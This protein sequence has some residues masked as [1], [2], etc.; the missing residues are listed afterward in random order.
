[1]GHSER[2]DREETGAPSPAVPA[3]VRKARLTLSLVVMLGANLLPLIGVALW[4]WKLFDLIVIY[5]L[6]TLVIGGFGIA[7]MALTTG[8]FAL[9]VV[10]FFIVHFGGFMTGHFVFLNAMF[11]DRSGSLLAGIPDKLRDMIVTDGLWVA[12]IGLAISHGLGFLFRF[13]IPWVRELWRPRGQ[14]APARDTG[15]MGAVMFGPYKRVMIMHVAII[16]GATL[17]AVFGSN[18]AFLALLVALKTASDLYALRREWKSEA[19]N[20]DAAMPASVAIAARPH[21]SRDGEGW[22]QRRALNRA[23]TESASQK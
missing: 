17:V 15:S 7:Q 20:G 6:E 8:W 14:R 22:S 3:S 9:F 23:R 21:A 12:L 1:M 5:W 2:R 10:P 16:F 19:S 13:L 11:G 18:F 4:G